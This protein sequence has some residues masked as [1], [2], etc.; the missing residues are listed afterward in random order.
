MRLLFLLK[1]DKDESQSSQQSVIS[2]C[3]PAPDYMPTEYRSTQSTNMFPTAAE[4]IKTV[5]SADNAAFS[6]F[7]AQKMSMLSALSLQCNQKSS[8]SFDLPTRDD[9][10]PFHVYIQVKSGVLTAFATFDHLELPHLI[11]RV[12]NQIKQGT[13]TDVETEVDLTKGKEMAFGMEVRN[14]SA[15]WNLNN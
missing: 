9:E 6:A 10:A 3:I 15:S 14:V 5:F 7:L 4:A 11:D 12:H 1:K 2:N 8:L 13:L